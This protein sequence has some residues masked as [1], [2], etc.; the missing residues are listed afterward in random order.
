MTDENKQINGDEKSD[1]N[2]VEKNLDFY[3]YSCK[4]ETVKNENYDYIYETLKIAAEKSG[5]LVIKSIEH[6]FEP[7]GLTLLNILSTSAEQVHASPEDLLNLII[8]VSTCDTHTHPIKSLRYVLERHDPIGGKISY[9]KEGNDRVNT[10]SVFP[11]SAE[12]LVKKY[13]SEF[14]TS[15]YL[16]AIDDVRLFQKDIFFYDPSRVG[17]RILSKLGFNYSDVKERE[18]GM[19]K[20]KVNRV[21]ENSEIIEFLGK[22]R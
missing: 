3:L 5:A 13:E 22:L 7:Q 9:Y 21:N 4:P 10:A 19:W 6:D 8:K 2:N 15:K 16:F 12:Y 11:R 18:K 20:A 14:D 17:K 1:F